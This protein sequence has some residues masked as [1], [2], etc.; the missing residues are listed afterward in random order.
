MGKQLASYILKIAIYIY[1]KSLENF[2]RFGGSQL[3]CQS[4]IQK[5]FILVYLL[6]KAANVP[7]FLFSAPHIKILC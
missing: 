2:V 3:T 7:M 5:H 4:F 6:R 1:H